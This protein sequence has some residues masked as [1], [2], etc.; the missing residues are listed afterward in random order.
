MNKRSVPAWNGQQ[1]G[2]ARQPSP[3]PSLSVESLHMELGKGIGVESRCV[4]KLEIAPQGL[5]VRC[6][7]HVLGA[8]R[9]RASNHARTSVENKGGG[10]I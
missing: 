6:T 7:H 9:P 2:E 1:G 4:T 10:L 3:A 5:S 8:A